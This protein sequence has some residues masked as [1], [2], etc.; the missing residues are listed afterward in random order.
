MLDRQP[1]HLRYLS[2]DGAGPSRHVLVATC[3]MSGSAAASWLHRFLQ[4]LQ[5]LGAANRHLLFVLHKEFLDLAA[6][7]LYSGTQTLD[8][9]FAVLL[10]RRGKRTIV[11]VAWSEVTRYTQ[12]VQAPGTSLRRISPG[13]TGGARS[14]SSA[15]SGIVDLVQVF[16]RNALG[17]RVGCVLREAAGVLSVSP[18][19]RLHRHRGIVRVT[20][21]V[22]FAVPLSASVFQFRVL[23]SSS[24]LTVDA[25]YGS[26]SSPHSR[27]CLGL[28]RRT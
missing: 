1:S 24:R 18:S 25:R 21:F 4:L 19:P 6:S 10:E 3:G 2:P 22:Y 20:F 27:S 7:R 23:V 11:V 28:R 12:F 14:E 5:C 9:G 16:S 17:L 15:T 8:V 13:V 26:G